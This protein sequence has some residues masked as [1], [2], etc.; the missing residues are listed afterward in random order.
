MGAA[1]AI[2]LRRERDIVQVYRGAGATDVRTARAPDDIGVERRLPFHMLVRH[3]VLRDAGNGRY[4]LDEPSWQALRRMRHRVVG[5]M[6]LIVVAL[7]AAGM[8]GVSIF[9]AGRAH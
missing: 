5:L 7:F 1:A 8:F 3:A 4:Y 9:N 2:I 6:L